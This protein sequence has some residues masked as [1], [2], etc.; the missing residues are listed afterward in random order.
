MVFL[1]IILPPP[2]LLPL[3]CL[4]Q[5]YEN[6][7]MTS[8]VWWS[9]WVGT[10]QQEQPGDPSGTGCSFLSPLPN[11]TC[12]TDPQVWGEGVIGPGG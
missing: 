1:T 8:P 7:T 11:T 4:T 5:V 2:T 6:V 10:Q 3:N 12:P 9:I